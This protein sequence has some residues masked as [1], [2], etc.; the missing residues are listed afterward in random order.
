MYHLFQ[1][2]SH[3]IWENSM[4]FCPASITVGLGSCV[5]VGNSFSNKIK[6]NCFVPKENLKSSSPTFYL[7]FICTVIKSR[8]IVGYTPVL[9]TFQF[10]LAGYD[11]LINS[12]VCVSHQLTLITLTFTPPF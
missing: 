8:S 6:F 3:S 4:A 12:S 10:I 5:E 11:T 9:S 1:V 2:N 7:V